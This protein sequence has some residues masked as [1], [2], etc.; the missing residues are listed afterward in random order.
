[1]S[2]LVMKRL[3]FSSKIS[4]INPWLFVILAIGLLTYSLSIWWGLPTTISWAPDAIHPLDVIEK[5]KAYPYP[6]LHFYI[7]HFVYVPF[8]LAAKVGWI[9]LESISGITTLMLV[10]RATSVLMAL[11]IIVSVYLTSLD[12]SEKQLPALLSAAFILGNAPLIYYGKIMNVDVPYI[13]WFSLSLIFYIRAIKYDTLIDYS[14]FA[15]I[16]ML[17]ICTKD[18]AYGL[19]AVPTILLA[20]RCFHGGQNRKTLRLLI[21][22]IIGIST[23]LVIHNIVFDFSAFED[24]FNFLGKSSY[25]PTDFTDAPI[26][27]MQRY[28]YFVLRFFKDIQFN[29]GWPMSIVSVGAIALTLLRKNKQPLLLYLLLPC[30]SYYGL[31]LSFIMYSRDR[32]VIPICLILYIFCGHFL[33]ELLERFQRV[34]VAKVGLWLT[35]MTLFTYSFFYANSVN[36]LMLTDSRYFVEDWML[37]HIHP[38]A[39][40]GF[41][42]KLRNHPRFIALHRKKIPVGGISSG[43]L[44][45][46][47]AQQDFS[48]LITS[49]GYAGNRFPKGHKKSQGFEKLKD[50]THYKLIF[51]HRSKPLWNFLHIEE[52]TPAEHDDPRRKTGNLNK[53]NP[54]I[55][56]YEKR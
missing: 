26:V 31:L 28:I 16:S 18:Q 19:V 53:I 9:N 14:L 30:L 6:P 4:E 23:F 36:L 37:S 38:P 35:L 55:C 10:G 12:V 49:S 25:R 11:G 22:T 44:E 17:S 21:P 40:V 52:P 15:L 20:Y 34:H 29:L 50:E 2:P 46:T 45:E 3:S 8:I 32:F 24:H 33:G 48:Y 43:K 1:M 56:M 41:V 42:E 7:L 39:T 5:T 13:F 27:Y 47:V 51:C 54:E